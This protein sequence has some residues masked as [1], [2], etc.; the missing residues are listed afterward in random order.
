MV[1]DSIELALATLFERQSTASATELAAFAGVSRQAAHRALKREVEQGK[2]QVEGLARATRYRRPGHAWTWPRQGLEE[3]VVWEVVAAL[4]AFSGL[5]EE[6]RQ[7]A[8]YAIT[9]MVNNAIDHSG[10]TRVTVAVEQG[11]GLL[12]FR[13]E[14]DGVGAFANVRTRARLPDDLAAVQ[15]ISKGRFTT[16][17]TRHRGE[18][19]FFT[20]KAVARF[21]LRAGALDWIVD[22]TIGEVALLEAPPRAGT[23]VRVVIHDPPSRPLKAVFD[24]YTEDFAFIRTRTVVKL[25]EHGVEF[26]SRSE[27]KRLLAGLERFH[28]VLVDFT[29]VRGIGQGFAD[30]VFRVWPAAHPGITVRP[31]NMSPA[32]E[33]M[34]RRTGAVTSG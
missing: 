8:Q 29:G 6:A 13:I 4:P 10:G 21:E 24:E 18:G 17:P 23:E 14:D 2:L 22:N 27:A 20:S 26:V 7:I 5:S 34:V 32:V 15:E 28:D 30:E 25:F 12:R 9:E 11:P 33:F 19:V 1:Y 31:V 16:D 3:H